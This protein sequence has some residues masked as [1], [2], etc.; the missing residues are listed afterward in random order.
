MVNEMFLYIGS[1]LAILSLIMAFFTKKG[2]GLLIF[3]FALI[4]GFMF[5]M[6]LTINEPKAIDVYRGKTRMK[7]NATTEDGK[8]ITADTVVVFNEKKNEM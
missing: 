7:I 1:V 5:F 2:I 8:V 4:G 6:A 3:L